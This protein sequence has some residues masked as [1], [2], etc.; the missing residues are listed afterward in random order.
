[1]KWMPHRLPSLLILVVAAPLLTGC[2]GSAASERLAAVT[3]TV[4]GVERLTYPETGAPELAWAFDTTALIGGYTVNDP[5]YQFGRLQ[6]QWLASD[7]AGNL[8]VFDSDGIRIL[9]YGPDGALIGRWGREGEGPGE[10]GSGFGVGS[11]AMAPGDTLWLVDRPNQR[12]TLIPVAEDGGEAVSIPLMEDAEAFTMVRE[13]V[14]DSTGPLG[15]LSS[16]TF[17]READTRPPEILVRFQR[18]TDGLSRDTIWSATPNSMKIIEVSS[19]GRT[20]FMTLGKRFEPQLS[21]VHF[22]HGELAVQDGA[23]YEIRVLDD[24]GGLRRIIR[25]DP[26]PRPV[27]D[28][29]RQ[30]VIDDVLAPPEDGDG[31]DSG[32][33]A[34]RR[35]T[36]DA[37]YFADVIPRIVELRV[38]PQDR[39][40]V[41]VAES[42]PDSI[43]RIDVYE[44]DGTLLGELHDLPL[45]AHFFGQDRAVILGRDELDVQQIQILRLV[46]EP[47]ALESASAAD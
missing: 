39:L 10:I 8:Y 21:W 18:G 34:R 35:A 27:T 32:A 45:P 28:A 25:R 38:D 5:D 26:P 44:P 43:T 12:F 29:D 37:L 23:A 36:A 22:S 41:G 19:G 17:D 30:A 33:A 24:H 6:P 40:W 15:Q 7:A 1:M 31:D 13:L 4:G 47:E 9:G 46:E 42:K 14:V 3:D 11:I 16:F 20:M 2:G